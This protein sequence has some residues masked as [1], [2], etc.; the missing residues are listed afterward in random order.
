MLI[1]RLNRRN[2]FSDKDIIKRYIQSVLVT[3]FLL[4][5][6]EVDIFFIFSSH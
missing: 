3:G 6:A 5:S 1:W 2:I 4:G